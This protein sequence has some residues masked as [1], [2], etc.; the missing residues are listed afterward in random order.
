MDSGSFDGSS[1]FLH[2]QGFDLKDQHLLLKAL[3][4]FNIKT[5]IHK[6]PCYLRIYILS[7]SKVIFRDLIKPYILNCFYYKL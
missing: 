7:E 2:T 6:D 4:K 1:Y 3:S 5:K